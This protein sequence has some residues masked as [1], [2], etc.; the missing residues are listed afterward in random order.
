MA[1]TLSNKLVLAENRLRSKPYLTSAALHFGAWHIT[2]RKDAGEITSPTNYCRMCLKYCLPR[3]S[4]PPQPD[5]SIPAVNTMTLHEWAIMVHDDTWTMGQVVETIYPANGNLMRLEQV[6]VLKDGS[7][8]KFLLTE[9]RRA[10]EA[11]V[12]EFLR[13]R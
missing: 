8:C 5:S 6:L 3:P 13:P 12:R 7:H 9:L 11:E 10:N 1:D 4:H 2:I